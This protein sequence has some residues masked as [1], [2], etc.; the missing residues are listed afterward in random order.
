M[1]PRCSVILPTYNRANTLPRAVASVL[2]QDLQDFELIIV[3][4][5]STD[6]TRDWLATLRD[7]RIRLARLEPNQGPS[8]ARN[9]GIA[10]AAAPVLAFLD[11]DDVYLPNRLAVPLRVFA[12]EP[13]V[14]CTLSSARKQ[15]R[16]GEWEPALLP[17]VKLASAAFEWA[18]IADLA[19]VESTS[20]TVRTAPAVAIGGFC[21]ALRRTEDREFLIRLSRLGAARILADVLY[22]KSLSADSTSDEWGEAG[23]HLVAYVRQRPEYLG[24]YRRLG[25]YLATKIVVANLRRRDLATVVSDVR[26]FRDAG[27][28]DVSFPRLASNHYRVRRYRR[29][30]A[31]AEALTSLSGPSGQWS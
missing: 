13:D 3:D 17:E 12:S 16:D 27:L 5:G 6:G 2:A 25:R 20:I 28:F 7:S 29:R 8:A 19:S 14:I 1:A 15:G 10:M 23:R 18:M 21:A 26:R 30:M 31:G 22:E 24:R 4:D 11:S 9:A